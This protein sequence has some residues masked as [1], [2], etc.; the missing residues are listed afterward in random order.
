MGRW[1]RCGVIIVR[2]LTDHVPRHVPI[3]ED[4]KKVVK[5]NIENLGVMDGELT[6]R[7][8]K[9]WKCYALKE[10]LNEKCKIQKN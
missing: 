4:G 3:I 6:P 9:H 10:F 1:K 8:K 5:F 7:A 2:Y